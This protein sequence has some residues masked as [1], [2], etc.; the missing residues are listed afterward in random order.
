MNLLSKH[1]KSYK[2]IFEYLQISMLQKMDYMNTLFNIYY[3][4]EIVKF[5]TNGKINFNFRIF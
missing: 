5:L 3:F 1:K 4:N 2:L